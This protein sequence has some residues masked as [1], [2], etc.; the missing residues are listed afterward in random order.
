VKIVQL[1][2]AETDELRACNALQSSGAGSTA[3]CG[4]FWAIATASG[5][6]MSPR[7][8]LL[9]SCKALVRAAIRRDAQNSSS[10]PMSGITRIRKGGWGSRV[11]GYRRGRP[12][13]A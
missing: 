11:L 8:R 1:D 13:A 4:C 6:R 10:T 12:V 7:S 2:N 3:A 9:L 5:C